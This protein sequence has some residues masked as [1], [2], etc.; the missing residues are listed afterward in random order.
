MKCICWLFLFA[1]C[2]PAFAQTNEQSSV[3]AETNLLYITDDGFL[4]HVR[5]GQIKMNPQKIEEAKKTR[6]CLSASEFPEGNWGNIQSG[7]QLSL[8]LEK[9]SFT[10]NEPIIATI[11]LRNVTN[12]VLT[13]PLINEPGKDGPIN[14]TAVDS[15]GNMLPVGSDEIT[16]ISSHDEKLFP[17][18]QKKFVERLGQVKLETNETF[19]VY[20]SITVSC[21][22]CV[23]VKSAKVPI[24]IE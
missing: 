12:Q 3:D 19:S 6:E 24:K 11:L 13:F 2:F 4:I 7:F 15:K 21:P 8:R 10:N 5:D 20:A 16:I 17:G 22:K 14:L 9:E 23:E 1:I 18:T